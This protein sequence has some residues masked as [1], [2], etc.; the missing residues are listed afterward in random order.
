MELDEYERGIAQ[1]LV[2]AIPRDLVNAIID[3]L[4]AGAQRADT[5]TKDLN[6]GHRSSAL[7]QE[8]HFRMNEAFH[9][10][11][12]A[13]SASPTPIH[14]N[15]L[16]VGRI[17]GVMLGRINVGPVWNHCRRSIKRRNLCAYN[18][19]L[20]HWVEADLF[21]EPPAHTNV[22]AFFVA[23]FSK[24]QSEA[25]I[26]IKIAV[27]DRHMAGWLFR[28]EIESFLSRYNEVPATQEDLALPRLKAALRKKNDNGE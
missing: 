27:P 8:R 19:A 15:N 25:P 24:D 2:E 12:A 28:E 23:E 21:E 26:A 7:G 17:A 10:V 16:I 22:L 18:N 13:H 6:Q 14:A 3:G 5:K 4:R 9:E 11:L 1:L 20:N